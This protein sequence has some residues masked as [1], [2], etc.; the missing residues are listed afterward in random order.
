MA[1]SRSRTVA[2]IALLVALPVGV[3]SSALLPSENDALV[4]TSTLSVVD[5]SV[6]V[7]HAGADFLPAHE[8]DVIAAGDTIRTGTGASAEFTYFEG[9]SIR[10]EANMEIVVASL[11]TSNSGLE[12]TLGRA[13]RVITKLFSGGSRYEVRTP[14]S[15]RSDGASTGLIRAPDSRGPRLHCS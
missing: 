12:Q 7:R 9:S 10:I 1:L 14:S 13:W 5:G 8:G 11:R 2:S 3:G 6:L 4:S 15:R